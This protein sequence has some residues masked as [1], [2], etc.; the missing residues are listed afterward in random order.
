MWDSISSTLRCHDDCGKSGLV[1]LAM[2]DFRL[3][4]ARIKGSLD[5]YQIAGTTIKPST[6]Q[7]RGNGKYVIMFINFG[8]SYRWEHIVM[9]PLSGG[10]T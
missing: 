10:D 5:F 7:Y 6:L 9:G 4:A 1:G 2:E 3:V 8:S